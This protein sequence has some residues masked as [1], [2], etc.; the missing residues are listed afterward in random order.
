MTLQPPL[1]PLED[2]WSTGFCRRL[3]EILSRSGIPSEQQLSVVCRAAV[4]PLEEEEGVAPRVLR[5]RGGQRWG[6]GGGWMS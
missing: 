3:R 2:V 1:Y 6:S 4:L 5:R